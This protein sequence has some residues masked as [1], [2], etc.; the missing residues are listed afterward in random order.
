MMKLKKFGL[1]TIII[2][3]GV[4]LIHGLTYGFSAGTIMFL[5]TITISIGQI[6]F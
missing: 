1:L 5:A 6:D 4:T 2:W 3:F